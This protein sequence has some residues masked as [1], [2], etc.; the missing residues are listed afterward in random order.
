MT[1]W[2]QGVEPRNSNVDVGGSTD[3]FADRA[4]AGVTTEWV[5]TR[6]AIS[7]AQQRLGGGYTQRHERLARHYLK[8]LQAKQHRLA[9]GY[10]P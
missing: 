3:S 4:M 9:R 6:K 2:R 7:L 1:D 10:E 5:L 8:K